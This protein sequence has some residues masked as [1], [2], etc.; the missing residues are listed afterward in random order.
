MILKGV[1]FFTFGMDV[2]FFECV[3]KKIKLLPLGVIF[4]D[5]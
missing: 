2:K 5:I 3:K 1:T 4:Q